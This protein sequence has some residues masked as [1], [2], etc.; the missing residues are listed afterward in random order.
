MMMNK[1]TARGSSNL[2]RFLDALREGG[3]NI[4]EGVFALVDFFKLY[5]D[6]KVKS[7]NGN[8]ANNPYFSCALPK[9]PGQP[10]DVPDYIEVPYPKNM[11][12]LHIS[13]H[14]Q[15][16]E[17]IVLVGITPPEVKY[18]SHVPFQTTV[19]HASR[20]SVA[21][22]DTQLEGKPIRNKPVAVCDDSR[23]ILFAGLGD[24]LNNLKINTPGTPQGTP[25]N[26]FEQLFV[27]IY[28]SDQGVLDEVVAA[29]LMAGYPKTCI[30]VIGISS[31]FVTFGVNHDSDTFSF[32]HRISNNPV[33]AAK[34]KA[35][36]DNPPVKVFRVTTDKKPRAPLPAPYLSPR[37]SGRTELELWKPVEN[38]R[39]AILEHH[40]CGFDAVELGTDVWLNES[41][42][43]SQQG[44]DNLGE[45]R[46]TT[47]FGTEA[48]VL[49]ENAFLVVY[50]VNHARVGKSL[51]ANLV[52]YGSALDNGVVSVSDAEF[53]GS[54]S[55][56]LDDAQ[57]ASLYAWKLGF[58]S[59][60]FP[61]QYTVIPT[62]ASPYGLDPKKHLYL[63]FRAYVDPV[64]K[65]GPA[66]HELIMDRVIVFLPKKI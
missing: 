49:P 14:F 46:D 9:A 53:A 3:A 42:L 39:L 51:Y 37:G 10:P 8:N 65:V 60:L 41:Y 58:Q 23:C 18:F 13:I 44:L 66:C 31:D 34:L 15:S 50:G 63:A 52:V 30:N 55:T 16:S 33:D 43:A 20:H 38:L 6:G 28:A 4:Q 40:A 1:E 22:D 19:S 45:S 61:D 57:S 25:G 56:Y 17:A 36:L 62:L 64:T 2:S 5:A 11:E 24:P 29:A 7:C 54:A 21:C 26:P 48:F 32:S 47:Y 35:Y 59:K 27:L 12:P